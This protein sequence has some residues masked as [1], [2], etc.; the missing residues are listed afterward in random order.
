[1]QRLKIIEFKIF[2]NRP[3]AA[4]GRRAGGGPEEARRRRMKERNISAV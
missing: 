3:Q 2:M 1:M 4:S